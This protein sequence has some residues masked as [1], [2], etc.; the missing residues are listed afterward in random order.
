MCRAAGSSFQTSGTSLLAWRHS[1]SIIARDLVQFAALVDSK[2]VPRA[3]RCAPIGARDRDRW[4]FVCRCRR[5][6]EWLTPLQRVESRARVGKGAG[7]FSRILGEAM[8]AL[9]HERRISLRVYL[10]APREVF[11]IQNPIKRN[12][13]TRAVSWLALREPNSSNG[14]SGASRGH[15]AS[16]IL[17]SVSKRTSIARW[18]C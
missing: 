9:D 16:Q 8:R 3:R 15:C 5:C 17:A 6:K 18:P 4:C 7:S 1:P 14:N 10:I 13:F 2:H 12:P 11:A